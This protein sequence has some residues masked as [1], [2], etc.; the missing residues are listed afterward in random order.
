MIN[1]LVICQTSCVLPIFFHHEKGKNME[2][3]FDSAA[4]SSNKSEMETSSPANV[5]YA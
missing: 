1:R 3:P 2:I 5:K 4:F